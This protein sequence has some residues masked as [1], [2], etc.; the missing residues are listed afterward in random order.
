MNNKLFTI[1]LSISLFMSVSFSQNK[2]D[3]LFVG[4][5]RG[6]L[7]NIEAGVGGSNDIGSGIVFGVG[8]DLLG[9]ETSISFKYSFILD[10]T[11]FADNH[12]HVSIFTV[13]YGLFTPYSSWGKI[14]ISYTLGT[15]YVY[16]YESIETE[17]IR[18]NY[19]KFALTLDVGKSWEIGNSTR[20]GW[21][22]FLGAG[23]KYI[24][25]GITMIVQFNNLLSR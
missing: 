19:T 12:N 6:Y 4:A 5:D 9:Q 7:M 21:N 18:N 1:L 15:K 24:Y 13:N 11:P 17:Y 8:G 22:L 20:M 10:Q 2:N 25:T 16:N 14:G 23:Q 3:T